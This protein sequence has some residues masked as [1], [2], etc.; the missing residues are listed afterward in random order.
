MVSGNEIEINLEL[1]DYPATGRSSGVGRWC[2]VGFDA[3]SKKN[4]YEREGAKMFKMAQAIGGKSQP[5]A[6]LYKALREYIK[7]HEKDE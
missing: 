4:P 6:L 1:E 2:H 5:K 7:A 3:E